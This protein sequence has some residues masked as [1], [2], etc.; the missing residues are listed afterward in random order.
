MRDN[1]RYRRD[2]DNEMQNDRSGRDNDRYNNDSNSYGR[3]SNQY[4][5]RPYEQDFNRSGFDYPMS[6]TGRYSSSDNEGYGGRSSGNRQS[7]YDNNYNQSYGGVN[8]YSNRRSTN[9]ED[10]NFRSGN[11][12]NDRRN[13]WNW[14]NDYDRYNDYGRN[15]DNDY[16]RNRGNNRQ[17]RGWWDKTK[18][19]VSSWFGDDDAQRRRTRDEMRND[20]N[21]GKG[22]KNYKKSSDRIKEDVNDRLSDHWMLDASNIEV[23]VKDTEVTLSGTVDDKNDKRTAEDIAESVSGVTNV[24]N[25][26]RVSKNE[27]TDEN[28]TT[29]K[30]NIRTRKNEMQHSNS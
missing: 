14:S 11:Y 4:Y 9:Y 26:L 12:G 17:D 1:N 16:N 7:D 28:E 10:R 2:N 27:D 22:P 30:T 18:D 24:Q 29:T 15:Y 19:E 13:D 23:E 20:S 25:N 21:R 6:N 3:Q 8:D 5:N